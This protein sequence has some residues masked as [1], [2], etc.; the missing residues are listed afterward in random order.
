[1]CYFTFCFRLLKMVIAICLTHL[2]PHYSDALEDDTL[3]C[4]QCFS[5][6]WL[7]NNKISLTTV[8]HDIHKLLTHNVPP[9]ISLISV[10]Y[11][12]F[13][14]WC[15]IMGIIALISH[16]K[17]LV[18]FLCRQFPLMPLLTPALPLPLAPDKGSRNWQRLFVM[19]MRQGQHTLDYKMQRRTE[20]R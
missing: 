15:I 19:G 20:V 6:S 3:G 17:L 11:P 16:S 7:L 9:F 4:T 10:F 12:F 5:P 1:M 18:L 13:C 8:F 14:S 2:N